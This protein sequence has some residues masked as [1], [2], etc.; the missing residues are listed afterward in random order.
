MRRRLTRAA[1]PHTM[2]AAQEVSLKQRL[3]FTLIIAAVLLPLVGCAGNAP[4]RAESLFTIISELN[5]PASHSTTIVITVPK[6]STPTDI[7]AAAES[8][9]AARRAQY[10][11]LTVKSF[12]EPADLNGVPSAVSKFEGAGVEHI[13]TSPP[14]ASERI[15]TH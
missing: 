1:S 15:P 14:P 4:T 12:T 9:I 3:A 8:V 11:L 13:F 2:E 7:K 5:D 10:A 6:A